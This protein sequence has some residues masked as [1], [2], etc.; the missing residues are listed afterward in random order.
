MSEKSIELGEVAVGPK[1]AKELAKD[2]YTHLKNTAATT[3]STGNGYRVSKT[4]T[5][6]LI[7]EKTGL[8]KEAQASFG[9]VL[10]ATAMAA[11]QFTSEQMI[12]RLLDVK[13][14][15]EEEAKSVAPISVTIPTAGF[16]ATGTTK[17]LRVGANPQNREEKV[18]TFGS[19]RVVFETNTSGE[20]KDAFK[21]QSEAIK[22]TLMSTM[23]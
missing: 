2:L 14:K 5:T 4:E 18:L 19:S 17:A 21:E 7:A 16:T 6:K 15:T 8:S 3:G 20:C 10:E 11:N 9:T 12:N 23:K 1:S 13:P 22:E